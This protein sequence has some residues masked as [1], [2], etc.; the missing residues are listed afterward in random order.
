MQSLMDQE[1]KEIAPINSNDYDDGN[2]NDQMFYVAKP[3]PVIT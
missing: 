3:S 1:S 2:L